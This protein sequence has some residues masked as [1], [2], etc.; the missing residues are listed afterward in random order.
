M[1]FCAQTIA[2]LLNKFIQVACL[3][4]LSTSSSSTH[5]HCLINFLKNAP[6]GLSEVDA[7]SIEPC[8]FCNHFFTNFA[9][10]REVLTSN[11]VGAF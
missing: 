9:V 1:I 11:L 7:H 10:A 2:K 8:V 3:K 4:I 5:T 6:E